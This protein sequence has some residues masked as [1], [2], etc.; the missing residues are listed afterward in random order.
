[1]QNDELHGKNAE[2]VRRWLEEGWNNGHIDAADEIFSPHYIH[3]EAVTP[4]VNVGIAH[5]KRNI[6]I[7]RDAFPDLHTTIL[8]QF[9]AG[10]RVMTRWKA[11]G[12]HKGKLFDQPPTGRKVT[13]HGMVVSRVEHGRI[14][15]EW[16]VVDSLGLLAQIGAVEQS[17]ARYVE[18]TEMN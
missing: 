13:V 4:E 8:E 2:L 18:G 17:V 1:M 10:D 5:I 9:S 14:V 15:E 12:T 11:H 6:R 7:Y 3:H 16:D